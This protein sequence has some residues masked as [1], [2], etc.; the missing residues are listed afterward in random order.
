MVNRTVASAVWAVKSR[1]R[2][3]SVPV[4]SF[5]R[6]SGFSRE[7]RLGAETPPS[8]P[9]PGLQNGAEDRALWFSRAPTARYDPRARQAWMRVPILSL[10][11]AQDLRFVDHALAER[12]PQP[13]VAARARGR[14]RARLHSYLDGPTKRDAGKEL[15]NPTSRKRTRSAV[16]TTAHLRQGSP[17]VV[18]AVRGHRAGGCLA[19]CF[20]TLVACEARP[21][22]LAA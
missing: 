2:M 8:L 6:L 1:V 15:A 19:E 11:R 10:H 17:S 7:F 13:K 4:A 5:S 18:A 20:L 9:P 12:A 3:R 22:S 14:S 16:A 21:R